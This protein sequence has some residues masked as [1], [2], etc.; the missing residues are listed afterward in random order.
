MTDAGTI[1]PPAADAPVVP[2]G[3]DPRLTPEGREALLG[4]IEG[5][6]LAEM[7]DDI[8]KADSDLSTP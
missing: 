4:L 2:G 6:A 3:G 8:S 7:L 5:D 1:K